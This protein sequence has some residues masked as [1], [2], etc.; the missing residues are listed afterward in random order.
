MVYVSFQFRVLLADPKRGGTTFMAI[1]SL[2]P[3]QV[4]HVVRFCCGSLP[5]SMYAS[6]SAFDQ[7]F[8]FGLIDKWL[9]VI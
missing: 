9:F 8:I 1:L 3:G 7:S 4:Y 6:R 5:C 2:V